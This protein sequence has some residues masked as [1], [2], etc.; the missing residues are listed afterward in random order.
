MW[1]HFR[2]GQNLKCRSAL[3]QRQSS[4]N[5]MPGWPACSRY[6][7]SKSPLSW[8]CTP[9]SDQSHWHQREINDSF[10]RHTGPF[11]L[12]KKNSN[13]IFF[14][15]TCRDRFKKPADPRA[16]YGVSSVF[17]LHLVSTLG[18]LSRSPRRSLLSL[19]SVSSRSPLSSESFLPCRAACTV[20]AWV[21][22]EMCTPS[23]ESC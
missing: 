3:K 21:R 8:Q 5:P 12:W 6:R 2:V 7:A 10:R 19:F 11:P 13:L 15:W 1:L 20:F 4:A 17:G 16:M 22:P 18:L 9:K 14:S 23:I